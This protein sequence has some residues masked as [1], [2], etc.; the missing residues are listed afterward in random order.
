MIKF[1]ELNKPGTKNIDELVSNINTNW[2]DINDALEIKAVDFKNKIIYNFEIEN[3]MVI[4]NVDDTITIDQASDELKKQVRVLDEQNKMAE[5]T[6]K[7]GQE[8]IE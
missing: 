5:I 1:L 8:I 3:G 2:N 4:Y 6:M 7:M